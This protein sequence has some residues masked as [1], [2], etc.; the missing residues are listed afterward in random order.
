MRPWRRIAVLAV[1][2]FLIL[3]FTAFYPLRQ[4]RSSQA[5]LRRARTE[6]AEKQRERRHLEVRAEHL[7]RVEEVARLARE[8]F[9]LARQDEILFAV[10]DG[11][12][13]AGR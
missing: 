6:L 5:D 8:R 1:G 9:Q 10:V 2:A 3:L 12:A 11:E 4:L 7:S 13:H